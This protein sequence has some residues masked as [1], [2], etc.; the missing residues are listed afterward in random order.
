MSR[1][2]SAQELHNLAM[3][4]VG[5]K[6]EKDGY[7]FIA[8]NSTLKKH[9]QF[10]CI[11]EANKRYFVIVQYVSVV[12]YPAPFDVIWMETFKEHARKQNAKVLY[13]QVGLGDKEQPEHYPRLDQ[14]YLL[15]F[16]GLRLL[17]IELN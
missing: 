17:D 3:N 6:L 10:V 2:L 16:E 1:T 4:T 15:Q 9:P 13:A 11:D 8:V 12:N 14:P 5:K 7:E